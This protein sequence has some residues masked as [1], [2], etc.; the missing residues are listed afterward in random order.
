MKSW[1]WDELT[2]QKQRL[3]PDVALWLASEYEQSPLARLN[4]FIS[5]VPAIAAF[6]DAFNGFC[7]QESERDTVLSD[8]HRD[9]D[10]DDGA[11]ERQRWLDSTTPVLQTCR[12]LSGKRWR[13][14]CPCFMPQRAA[15]GRVSLF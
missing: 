5:S 11:A 14:G 3:L 1:S 2:R 9:F 10:V 7:R 12:Q 6:S 4:P 13:A 15:S 8:P